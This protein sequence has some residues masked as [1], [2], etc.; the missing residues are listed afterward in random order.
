M[1]VL[2]YRVPPVFSLLIWIDLWKIARRKLTL[3]EFYRLIGLWVFTH[4][5]YEDPTNLELFIQRS[6][7]NPYPQS[8]DAFLR[9]CDALKTHDTL[10]RLGL[11]TAPTHVIVPVFFID[12]F[13]HLWFVQGSSSFSQAL[14][15]A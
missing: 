14:P 13:P 8:V 4:Q 12:V 15:P 7:E 2:G 6:T 5:F 1:N 3:G 9:Q 10:D 11:V